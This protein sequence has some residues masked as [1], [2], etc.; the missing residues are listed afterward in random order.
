MRYY[1]CMKCVIKN[2][3]KYSTIPCILNADGFVDLRYC[4]LGCFKAEL[5]QVAE[6]EELKKQ[7][8]NETP[9]E[10]VIRGD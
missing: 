1:K 4:G 9:P 2:E 10:G 3:G 8:E 7:H 6:Y 5:I